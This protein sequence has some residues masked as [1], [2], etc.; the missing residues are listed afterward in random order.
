MKNG[1]LYQE[2]KTA[3]REYDIAW[4]KYS[5][6]ESEMKKELDKATKKI[7]VGRVLTYV[8]LVL[9][10]FVAIFPFVWM[11]LTSFKLSAEALIIP[12]SIF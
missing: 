6:I 10:A 12:P 4:S 9:G 3:K 2:V 11:I 8:V 1:N 5:K 7:N